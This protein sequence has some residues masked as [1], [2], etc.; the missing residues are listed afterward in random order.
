MLP[1]GILVDCLH[2]PQNRSRSRIGLFATDGRDT[3]CICCKDKLRSF[4]KRCIMHIRSKKPVI[5]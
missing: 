4:I 2:R 3:T 5:N 1:K